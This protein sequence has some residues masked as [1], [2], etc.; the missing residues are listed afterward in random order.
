MARGL[1]A[2]AR[3]THELPGAVRTLVRELFRAQRAERA[4]E[5]ADVSDAVRG[6]PDAAPLALAAHL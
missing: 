4:L 1:G 2:S 6:E 5:A 3:A